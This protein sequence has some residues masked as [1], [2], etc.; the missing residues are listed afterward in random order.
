MVLTDKEQSL[1]NMIREANTE[2]I[3]AILG[4]G[5]FSFTRNATLLNII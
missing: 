2:K 5:G 3:K 4:G 1:D